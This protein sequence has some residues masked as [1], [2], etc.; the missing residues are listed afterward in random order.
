MRT[1]LARPQT[2][3][4]WLGTALLA[5]LTVVAGAGE[6]AAQ[7]AE[8]D[9]TLE[10]VVVTATRTARA[11][12]DVAVPT[13]VLTARQAQADGDLRLADALETVPGVQLTSDFGTGIQVQG[14]D[15]EYT[16]V[17]IDGQPVVGRTAGVLNLE[18]LSLRGLD[19]VEVVKGP[20]S[21][22][23]GSEA[24]AGVVNLV[25]RAPQ[26]TGAT[27]ELRGGS[28]G[29]STFAVEADLAGRDLGVA[30]WGARVALDRTDSDGYDLDPDVLGATGPETAETTADLRVLGR[31]SDRLRLSLGARGTA[32]NDRLLYAF[33][34]INGGVSPIDQRGDRRDWSLHPE[35]Q[36][37]FGGRYALRMTG[38]VAG[39]RLDTEV[40]EPDDAGGFQTTYDDRFEQRLIKAETQLDALWSGQHSTSLGAGAWHDR[41][42]GAQR[43]GAEEAPSVRNAFAFVQHDWQP[44]RRL[45]F[46][47]SARLDAIE[48]VGARLSPKVAALVRPTETTRVRLS[49]G[50]GFK[51]PDFRQLY[52]QFSNGI[53]GY[54]LFGTAGLLGA[55]DRFEAQGRYQPVRSGGG[56]TVGLRPESSI[57][58]NAEVSGRVGGVEV[59]VGAFR[60]A[61]R[62]LIDTYQAA[63]LTDGT[64]VLSYR[65]VDRVRTE[66]VTV[67]AAREAGRWQLSAGY[68]WLRSRD[69][70]VL[71]RIAGGTEFVRDQDTGRDTRIGVGDYANLF[72]RSA[73]SGTAR[74]GYR[75]SDWTGSLRA[76]WR[77]RYGLADFDGNG[78]PAIRDDE[79]VPATALFDLTLGWTPSVPQL[80]GPVTLQLGVDNVLGTTL[81]TLVPT[82]AGRR[83]YASIGLSF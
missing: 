57:A 24:L 26:Q 55:L 70:D 66:G 3:R 22:L 37:T 16:L 36:L 5:A 29:S 47:A 77:S 79:F 35:A 81:P 17:L 12:E 58:V 11:L 32:G 74:L 28:F 71:D 48:D 83:L 65:N 60:N 42:V 9:T 59:S 52:L 80:P 34:D 8:P 27:F 30:G 46:N 23:Y 62:D 75:Q 41:L 6:A 25:T 4:Q 69:L 73:H 33:E 49:V 21:S 20:S 15:P 40:L 76:R 56:G 1:Q 10:T 51:A 82:L 54:Q 7:T 31:V 45:A 72:G 67:N 50:S 39:F 44:S 13:T 38:Y 14:L 43:Y 19:R 2:L 18:R 63:L 53:G 78:I 64:P 68:Q 61:V